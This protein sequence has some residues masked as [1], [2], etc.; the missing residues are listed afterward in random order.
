MIRHRAIPPLATPLVASTPPPRHPPAAEPARPAPADSPAV[1]AQPATGQ[2]PAPAAAPQ[3]PLEKIVLPVAAPS[4]GFAAHVIAQRHGFFRA[5]GLDAEMPIMRT[6]LIA[7]AL[8]AGEADYSGQAGP[9]VRNALAGMPF[10]LIAVT[11]DKSTRWIVSQP[12]IRTVAALKGKV[13]AVNAIG[14]SPH[15]S[16]ILALDQVGL[17]P[18]ADVTWLAAGPPNERFLTLQQ[19]GAHATVIGGSELV[20][21]DALGLHRLLRLEDVAPLPETALATTTAKLETNPQQAK[22][23]LRAIVRALQFIKTD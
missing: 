14:S 3:Q 21:S 23:A 8:V 22:R 7:A 13:V 18:D 12:D 6:N 5:E 11:V 1:P 16:G 9:I 15:D 19:G 20:R 4:G 17:D 2:A 10:R